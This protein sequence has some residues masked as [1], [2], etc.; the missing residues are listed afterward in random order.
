MRA[1]LVGM[2]L[3][4]LAAGSTAAPVAA[5]VPAAADGAEAV[6]TGRLPRTALPRHYALRLRVDPRAERFD[7]EVELRLQL[8]A[9]ADHV[10]LHGK[11]LDVRRVTVVDAGGTERTARWRSADPGGGVARVDFGA[12]LPAQA[13]RLRF[14]YSAPYSRQLEGLYKA[15]NAGKAYIVSQ[16]EAISARLAFPCLDEPSFKSTFDLTLDIPAGQQAVANTA[17]R[18]RQR[19]PDGWQRLAFA[20]TPPLPTYLVALAVGP[21]DIVDGPAVPASA[22]RGQAVPLRGVAPAGAGPRLKEALDA[23]PQIVTALE[24]YFGQPYAFGKLDLLAATDFSAGAME[25]PGLIVFRAPLLLLDAKSPIALH[26]DSFTVN[27]H[28]LAHQWFGDTV[29]MPWWDDVWL[30]EAFASW[31]ADKITQQLRP[32]YRAELKR[33]EAAQRAMR[34]DSLASARRIRQP[35]AD[36]GDIEGA[37]DGI[38]YSKGAAVLNMF[39]AWLGPDTFRAGIRRYLREHAYGNATAD[40]LIAALAQAGDQ[41][42]RL[43]RAMKSFL[44]QAGVPLLQTRLECG[45]GKAVLQVTQQRYLPLGSRGEAAQRWGLPLCLRLGQGTGSRVEC[46]LVEAA[47]ERIAL[48]GACPDWYL[49]NA[50]GRGYYR[51]AMAPSDLDA[52]TAASGRLSDVEQL[53]FADAIDAGFSRGDLGVGA[54]LS[55]ARRLAAAPSPTVATALLPRLTWL[56][57]H[58][59][60]AATRSRLDAWAAALYRD[61]LSRLGYHRRGGE[62]EDDALLRAELA[63]F[64]GVTLRDAAVRKELL[65]QG[66]ALLGPHAEGHVDFQAADADLMG[67]VLTVLVQE[68]G[69]PAI[70]ALQA[71]LARQTDPQRRVSLAAA[72]GA[73]TDPA[74]AEAAR[75]FALD[76]SLSVNESARLLAVNR[77]QRDNRAAYWDWFMA[78]FDAVV[79]RSTPRGRG[80]LPEALGQGRCSAAES[81]AL[82]AWFTPRLA[83]LSGAAQ[84]LARA[85]EQIG[86]CAALR[87]HQPQG[88]LGDWLRAQDALAA[89]RDGAA[90]GAR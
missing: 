80:S 19:L 57:E 90:D 37:F 48:G 62:A 38:T 81:A 2:L 49:P 8:T 14:I 51:F 54:L 17:L 61:R 50:D 40:D 79:A 47:S 89:P 35:I 18:T 77:A 86:L 32:Q 52:L 12:T 43:P 34:A 4:L 75:N 9:A 85:Q 44:E 67:S 68:R 46:H 5:P 82:A 10:W 11:H 36:Q 56:R 53:A 78:H 41:G 63:Q 21:W 71:E 69:A 60:D 74:A 28:E 59:A 23:T 87:E 42:E 72:I 39:E 24:D 27:A 73:T 33:A 31:M 26:R 84:S 20:T 25:N 15:E 13:L 30:N 83:A 16:M 55:A 1:V 3:L 45:N 64:L 6:P 76:A 65:A 7:G 58:L 88:A 70:A 29:T 22:L 66:D